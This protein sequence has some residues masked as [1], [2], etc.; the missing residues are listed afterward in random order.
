MAI[1]KFPLLPI[2]EFP[3]AFVIFTLSPRVGKASVFALAA[4]RVGKASVSVIRF[5]ELPLR[6]TNWWW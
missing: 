1:L 2:F 6:S 4:P 5:V 3:A